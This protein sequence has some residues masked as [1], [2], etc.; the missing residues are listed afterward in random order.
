MSLLKLRLL[1]NERF[2]LNQCVNE[3]GDGMIFLLRDR[4]NF[5]GQILVG[6]PKGT[7]QPVSD[8]VLGKPT[9][10]IIFFLG[11]QIA[12]F[13]IV[14]KLRA[15]MKLSGW[16]DI[17]GFLPVLVFGPPFTGRG[18]VFQPKPD[19]INLAVTTGTLRFFLVSK[20]PFA[21]GQRLVGQ[22]GKLGNIGGCRGGWIIQK[23]S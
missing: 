11:N 19:R 16:I 17:I 2:A 22:A 1:G 4:G 8:Q 15:L 3:C 13:K 14:R 12:H 18:K 21:S 5:I 9:G 20:N 7:S 6:K 23:I 10:K